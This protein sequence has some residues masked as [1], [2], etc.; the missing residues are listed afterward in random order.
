MKAFLR[1]VHVTDNFHEGIEYLWSVIQQKFWILELRYEFRGIKLKCVLCSK[2][3]PKSLQPQIA[4]LP[5]ERLGFNKKPFAFTGIDFF[6]PFEIRLCRSSHK[7]W[8]CL[9]TCLTTRAVHIEVCH[10]LSTDSCLSFES[11]KGTNFVGAA[12]ELREFAFL[13]KNDTRIHSHLAERSCHWKFNPPASPHFGVARE[14]LVRSGKKAMFAVLSSRRLNEETFSTTMCL[15]EQ[16]L[17][18]R[19]FTEISSDPQN[20]EATTPNQFLL[21]RSTVFCLS[22]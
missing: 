15:V 6:G 19:P 14:R 18:S 12:R 20:L 8:C 4:D 10:G 13:L 9:F 3:Q 21:N 17:N 22:F 11:D 1:K 16:I 7:R 5:V 2:R